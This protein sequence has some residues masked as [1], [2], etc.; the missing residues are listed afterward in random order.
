MPWLTTQQFVA[1]FGQTFKKNPDTFWVGSYQDFA[2]LS[3]RVSWGEFAVFDE[4]EL[5]EIKPKPITLC[6]VFE[7]PIVKPVKIVPVKIVEEG[8]I[9]ED[10]DDESEPVAKTQIEFSID[11]DERPAPIWRPK[12][13]GYCKYCK[14][15]SHSSPPQ[16]FTP[17]QRDCCCGWCHET[18]GRGHG[19]NCEHRDKIDW[20]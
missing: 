17:E 4:E 7:A 11:D 15:K 10:S 5:W 16:W 20:F 18:K 8:E 14:F 13:H 3:K 2:T 6:V 1:K 19:P 12:D 9:E